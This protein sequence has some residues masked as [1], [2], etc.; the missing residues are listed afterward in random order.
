[1]LYYQSIARNMNYVKNREYYFSRLSIVL[2]V[3]FSVVSLV[4]FQLLYQLQ[5]DSDVT[6]Q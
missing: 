5:V 2:C 3:C 4:S 6:E 1:M